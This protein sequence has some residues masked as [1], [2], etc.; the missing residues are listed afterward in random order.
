MN[1]LEVES[2]EKTF[3]KKS[4]RK[5]PRLSTYT[6]EGLAQQANSRVE[7][8]NAEQDSNIVREVKERDEDPDKLLSKGQSARIWSELYKVLD[9]SDVVVQVPLL[10]YFI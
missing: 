4:T 10:Y 9:A 7:S 3:G 2:F 6:I 1:L 8:Y 5:R